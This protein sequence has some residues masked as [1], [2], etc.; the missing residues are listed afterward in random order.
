MTARYAW[1][2]Q[3]VCAQTDPELWS[4]SVGGD[5]RVP[6][7]ICANCPVRPQCDAPAE[8]LHAFEG[9]AVHGVWGGRSR[10][11]RTA[12]RRQQAA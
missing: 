3:A 10:R 1:M 12:G 6:K 9:L 7:R 4:S 5:T 11:Q 8:Q 2:D